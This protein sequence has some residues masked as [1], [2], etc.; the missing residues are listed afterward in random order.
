MGVNKMPRDGLA[1]ELKANGLTALDL[2]E[3]FGVSRSTVANYLGER[4][5]KDDGDEKY[6]SMAP[7]SI[8]NPDACG[9]HWHDLFEAYPCGMPVAFR[10]KLLLVEGP[11]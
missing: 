1:R 3:R 2:M 8:K 11:R 5:K 7:H 10:G 4:K 9:K 6:E